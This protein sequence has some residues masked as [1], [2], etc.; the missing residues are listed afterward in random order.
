M[1]DTFLMPDVR[2]ASDVPRQLTLLLI[3]GNA[4][5]QVHLGPNFALKAVQGRA[6]HARR[7]EL[8]GP[9]IAI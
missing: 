9:R 2:H 6:E 7:L 8:I 4:R 3:R 5:A 1:N